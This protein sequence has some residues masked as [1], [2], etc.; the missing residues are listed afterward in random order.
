MPKKITDLEGRLDAA[1][2]RADKNT[3]GPMPKKLKISVTPEQ[4]AANDLAFEAL[5][6]EAVR[7]LESRQ[8]EDGLWDDL[9]PSDK[10]CSYGP[11]GSFP[12]PETA[13]RGTVNTEGNRMPVCA[14]HLVAAAIASVRGIGMEQAKLVHRTARMALRLKTLTSML[15]EAAQ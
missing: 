14:A 1:I 4:R 15:G 2:K 10:P 5:T 6:R 8:R 7:I 11:Q 12:K 13:C 3:G 9:M